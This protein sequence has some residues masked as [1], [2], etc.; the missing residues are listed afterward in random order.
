MDLVVSTTDTSLCSQILIII[1]RYP[2]NAKSFRSSHIKAPI[3]KFIWVQCRECTLRTLPWRLMAFLYG[4]ALTYLTNNFESLR[5]STQIT[6]R[7]QLFTTIPKKSFVQSL[8]AVSEV[9]VSSM[10][11]L[12]RL[13]RLEMLFY[14]PNS[15]I[16]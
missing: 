12:S 5:S 10:L 3:N 7:L 13:F 6:S 16:T 11:F 14:S 8:K 9:H 15:N 1:G 2:V 4:N